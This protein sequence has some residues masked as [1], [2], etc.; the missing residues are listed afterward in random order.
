M[1]EDL[2][3][4]NVLYVDY[5]PEN[6]L[7]LNA[8]LEDIDV[9]VMPTLSEHEV[10]GFQ[11]EYEFSLVLLDVLMLGADGFKVVNFMHDS[12]STKN[13][14]II[15]LTVFSKDEFFV[16]KGYD[17]GAVYYFSKSNDTAI[18]RYK[19]NVFLQL[20][21]KT[22]ELELLIQKHQ[23][24]IEEIIKQRGELYEMMIKDYLPGL[25][26]AKDKGRNQVCSYV[27]EELA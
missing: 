13:I 17:A 4:P 9:L 8:T 12:A 27:V 21:T 15:F 22:H 24:T 1:I 20:W 16:H 2:P 25:Y 26:Q 14:V 5:R 3:R 6:L 10:L 7:A 23:A 11:L 18:L 19:V